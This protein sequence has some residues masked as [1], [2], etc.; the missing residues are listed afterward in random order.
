MKII[1]LM[2]ALMIPMTTFSA[3]PD[4]REGDRAAGEQAA[5]GVLKGIRGKLTE[6]MA[7]DLVKSVEFCH[8]NAIPLTEKFWQEHPRVTKVKRTSLKIRNPGNAPD[9]AETKVLKAWQKLKDQGKP[10]PPFTLESVSMNE[11][12]YYKPLMVEGMCLTCHGQPAGDLA[13]TINQKYPKDKATGYKDG[14]FRGLIR[15]SLKPE[16]I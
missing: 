10:L 2:F 9:D 16:K 7:K 3:G 12:R 4:S 5:V 8:E 1:I 6:E 11:V 14:D 13:K 15:V